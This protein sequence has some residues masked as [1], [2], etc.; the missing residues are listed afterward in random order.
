MLHTDD[1]LK[2]A[3][4]VKQR[5]QQAFGVINSSNFSLYPIKIRLVIVFEAR[6]HIQLL[7]ALVQSPLFSNFSQADIDIIK[8]IPLE[9]FKSIKN[10]QLL[11]EK[12]QEI[13]DKPDSIRLGQTVVHSISQLLE[14]K[15]L[16]TLVAKIEWP[17]LDKLVKQPG[18]ETQHQLFVMLRTYLA[19]YWQ[20][21]KNGCFSYTAIPNNGITIYNIELADLL[22][23][24]SSTDS[25]LYPLTEQE[26]NS[27]SL[28]TYL[29]PGVRTESIEDHYA[30]LAP[31]D[32]QSMSK[33]LNTHIISQNGH[34]LI[35]VDIIRSLLT[36]QKEEEHDEGPNP[37]RALLLPP[38]DPIVPV[39]ALDIRDFE[40]IP[41][42]YFDYHLD[43]ADNTPYLTLAEK[44]RLKTFSKQ[45]VEL[46][47][48]YEQYLEIIS[49]K[50]HLLGQCR[51]LAERLLHNGKNGTGSIDE[52][53]AGAE[54]SIHA[55]LD[56]YE[57][58]T[59]DEAALPPLLMK[60]IM[61]LRR[62]V[63]RCH[64]D[65]P[66]VSYAETCT[67][68]S[69]QRML[70]AISG[71]EAVLASICL[72]ESSEDYRQIVAETK[73]K[74]VE[75]IRQ[76]TPEPTEPKSISH[77]KIMVK[78]SNLLDVIDKSKQMP[79]DPEQTARASTQANFE[80]LLMP[81]NDLD[82][83][84]KSLLGFEENELQELNGDDTISRA[85]NHLIGKSI[86]R[87][88][89]WLRLLTFI[90]PEKIKILH[91]PP[92][93][94]EILQNIQN[95]SSIP[96]NQSISNLLNSLVTIK[97]NVLLAA[98]KSVHPSL[99]FKIPEDEVYL[100][101]YQSEVEI[102][103][104]VLSLLPVPS[105]EEYQLLQAKIKSLCDTP[106][107]ARVAKFTLEETTLLKSVL[108]QYGEPFRLLNELKPYLKTIHIRELAN[109]CIIFLRF[110]MTHLVADFFNQSILRDALSN[111]PPTYPSQLRQ[112]FYQFLAT[113]KPLCDETL[114]NKFVSVLQ[115]T[116]PTWQRYVST[117]AEA[118]AIKKIFPKQREILSAIL[119]GKFESG[120]SHNT[121][122]INQLLS[123]FSDAER[124]LYFDRHREKI[125]M[126][127]KNPHDFINIYN[128][129]AKDPVRCNSLF[130]TFMG[131]FCDIT[132]TYKHIRLMTENLNLV[133]L[134]QYL[135]QLTPHFIQQILRTNIE[136]TQ[137]NPLFKNI[138][139]VLKKLEDE[140]QL[141]FVQFL[142]ETPSI[143]EHLKKDLGEYGGAEKEMTKILKQEAKSLFETS[144]LSLRTTVSTPFSFF[145]AGAA[146]PVSQG[147]AELKATAS[148]H[149]V[150]Y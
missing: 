85:F 45:T 110:D 24:A 14:S 74:L 2:L 119:D 139:L 51:V 57:K 114:A 100:V 120:L 3:T 4:Q 138:I 109:L 82:C 127:I 31:K 46:F 128:A 113:L 75:Q 92:L 64:P 9:D 66:V 88:D 60:E 20:R 81:A 55:F 43:S 16:S 140:N 15:G 131:K 123:H 80:K 62:C 79:S 84:I 137:R 107:F 115:Q 52:A 63:R 68:A 40:Q 112:G 108:D 97:K 149:A 126:T 91:S 94:K 37:K 47:I 118:I 133:H 71:H 19:E 144:V 76:F 6:Q 34:Y 150:K 17:I 28:M 121:A 111:P 21:Q 103:N 26:L 148:E 95:T 73:R 35:P 25:T 59:V 33:L 129:V 67:D 23:K 1:L 106:D 87:T 65:E 39:K 124:T 83:L 36:H 48:L 50:S 98:I 77:D 12:I 147:L 58:L 41:Q 61:F 134:K 125:M 54:A 72:D 89:D 38:T 130:D 5:A 53:G 10:G 44:N 99:T 7:S 135:H 132:H 136:G 146:S 42:P 102:L 122:Q 141:V 90:S 142:F 18:P 117:P 56:F 69:Y 22:Y 143:R 30:D 116:A 32:K 29:M 93:V 8:K 70:I 145:S 27:L 11:Y 104:Q 78:A 49:R 13:N 105:S 96:I 86:H 101:F